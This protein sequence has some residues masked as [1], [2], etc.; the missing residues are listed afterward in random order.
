[1]A[2]L[3]GPDYDARITREVQVG[4][5]LIEILVS[6]S[7]N[8]RWTEGVSAQVKFL[9][10]Y[11]SLTEKQVRFALQKWIDDGTPC[12]SIVVD[13]FKAMRIL[14]GAKFQYLFVWLTGILPR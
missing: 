12:D 14:Q 10:R 4:S 2:S 11:R 9:E 1:M 5:H 13:V 8:S 7:Q 6:E 3:K